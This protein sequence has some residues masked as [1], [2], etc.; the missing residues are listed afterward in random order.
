MKKNIKIRVKFPKFPL[1]AIIS[2]FHRRGGGVTFQILLNYQGGLG[3]V[4]II[5]IFQDTFLATL[6]IRHLLFAENQKFWKIRKD[7][8]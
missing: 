6:L 3:A 1:N 4:E 8:H 2:E 5:S 7:L